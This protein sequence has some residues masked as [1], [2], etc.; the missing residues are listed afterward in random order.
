MIYYFTIKH[1][2]AHRNSNASIM[3]A[4]GLVAEVKRKNGLQGRKLADVI[5]KKIWSKP[6][7]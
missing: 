1:G 2:A 3:Q 4:R 5:L 6:Q 7:Y